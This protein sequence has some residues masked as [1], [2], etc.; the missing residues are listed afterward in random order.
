M[1]PA[2][3]MSFVVSYVLLAPLVGAFADS[4]PK[5]RVMLITNVIKVFGCVLMLLAIHPLLAYAVV[6][7]GAPPI[8]PRS[9]ASS[10]SSCRRT[11]SWWP[12]A[13][14]RAPP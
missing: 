14:S 3:K 7:F 1:T 9:T 4:M 10:P 11:S 6:G 5:G 8:R 12:T 13:G 2:L